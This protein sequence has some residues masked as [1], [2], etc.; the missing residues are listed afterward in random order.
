MEFESMDL[1]AEEGC[2]GMDSQYRGGKKAHTERKK[3]NFMEMTAK[4]QN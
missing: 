3:K 2:A 1:V 4:A